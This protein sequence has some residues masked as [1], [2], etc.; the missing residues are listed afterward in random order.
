MPL[1]FAKGVISPFIPEILDELGLSTDYEIKIF[2]AFLRSYRQ[3][4][5]GHNTYRDLYFN[6]FDRRDQFK[7]LEN[8]KV[9]IQN[10]SK[11]PINKLQGDALN[12]V[13]CKK[14]NW[15]E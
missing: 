11:D 8:C 6:V 2:K 5:P 13:K 1:N 9:V 4:G 12:K 7:A 10:S 14:T 3:N 15:R